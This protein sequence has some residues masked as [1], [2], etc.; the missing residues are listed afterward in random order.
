[1][2]EKRHHG[3]HEHW[4]REEI[5]KLRGWFH[6]D[7]KKSLKGCYVKSERTIENVVTTPLPHEYLQPNDLPVN[8]TW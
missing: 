6:H 1:M 5:Q 2:S 7:N 4:L 3:R 8:Y